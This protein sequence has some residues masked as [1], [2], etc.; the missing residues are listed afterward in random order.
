LTREQVDSAVAFT[1]GQHDVRNAIASPAAATYQRW[2]REL[3]PKDRASLL[4]NAEELVVWYGHGTQIADLALRGNP[5]ARLLVARSSEWRRN[6]DSTFA[7]PD[8]A[9]RMAARWEQIVAYMKQQGVRVANLSW[10]FSA[11]ELETELRK[12]APQMADSSRSR[13]AREL[14]DIYGQAITRAIASAPEIL[15]VVT[16][17]NQAI[18]TRVVERYPANLAFSN[19]LTVGGVDDSGEETNFTSFGKVD[20][21]ANAQDRSVL[22]PSGKRGFS[23]GGSLAAPDVVNL[24]GKLWAL[25]PKASVADIRR[26]ILNGAETTTADDGRTIRV[27][28]PQRSLDVLERLLKDR[29][30]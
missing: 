13:R 18:D 8:H 5:A 30:R 12:V 1:V 2:F 22:F 26:A 14:F 10:G 17:G 7:S 27:L 29:P 15:F 9:R 6:N 28:H 3:S 23:S 19:V 16:A 11:G 4:A 21:Y 20:V 24:V 25:Y